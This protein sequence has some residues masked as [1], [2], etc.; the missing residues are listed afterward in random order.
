M[1]LTEEQVEHFYRE[2]YV[3]VLGTAGMG[4]LYLQVSQDE[5]TEMVH[6]ALEHSLNFFD[7]APHYG[8]GLAE[9]RLGQALEGVKRDRYLISSKVGR[10]Y[11]TAGEWITDFSRDSILR[12][13]EGTLE[14]LKTDRVDILH[15]HDPDHHYHQALTEGFPVLAELRSQGV[16]KAIGAGMN[17]WEM[18]VD[19]AREADFDCFLL[20][21]HYTL[22]DQDAL[23]K[24]L[25]LCQERQISVF[26][27]GILNTGILATGAI[28]GAKYRYRE[29]PP[30][31]MRRVTRLEEICLQYNVPLIAAATQFPLAHPAVT[32]LIVGADVAQHI[33]SNLKALN[34]PIPIEFWHTLQTEELLAASVPIPNN[35]FNS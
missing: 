35:Q 32:S 8:R 12:S 27:G 3:L 31:I 7:T 1:I 26:M 30:E 5:A 14:R 33:A 15:L 11:N 9:T 34:T 6:Y 4:G 23:D 2:G 19:F 28:P 20:A 13:L 10:L 18:L 21:G 17:Q 29:A 22:L 24:F 25:P 16:I